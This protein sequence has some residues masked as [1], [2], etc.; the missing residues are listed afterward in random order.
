MFNSIKKYFGYGIAGI[1]G[2][3]LTTSQAHA[4]LDL[5]GVSFATDDYIAVALLILAALGTI[6]GVKR[7]L[8][9][10]SR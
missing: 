8:G 2:M 7:V 6:W 3:V 4:A 5:T 10:A 9:V 1:T